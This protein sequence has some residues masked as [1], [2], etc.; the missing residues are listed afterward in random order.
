M[1]LVVLVQGRWRWGDDGGGEKSISSCPRE[2]R[3]YG[4]T[5]LL[6]PS[7]SSARGRRAKTQP[8]TPNAET[9]DDS[10]RHKTGQREELQLALFCPPW[11]F[12]CS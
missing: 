4:A 10:E 12:E 9:D 7:G 6:V 11:S 2:L 8:T 1:Q 3:S 5:E